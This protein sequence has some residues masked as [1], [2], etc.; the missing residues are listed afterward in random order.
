MS[1]TR[2]DAKTL[3]RDVFVF[4]ENF[5]ETYSPQD[6]CELGVYVHDGVLE[7]LERDVE[8]G[9]ETRVAGYKDWLY[10]ERVTPKAKE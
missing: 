9:S 8:T 4:T 10:F 5:D 6:G 1:E 2:Y 7:I 3:Y